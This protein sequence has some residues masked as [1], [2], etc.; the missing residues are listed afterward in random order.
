LE[1]RLG[2]ARE[3]EQ[4]VAQ[5]HIDEAM[6]RLTDEEVKAIEGALDRFDSLPEIP[7]EELT[8]RELKALYRFYGELAAVLKEKRSK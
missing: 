3:E 4:L 5:E 1:D 6:G 8:D 7:Y 2:V